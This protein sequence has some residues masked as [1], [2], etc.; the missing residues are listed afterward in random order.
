MPTGKAR[1]FNMTLQ[2]LLSWWN[3]IFILPFGLGLLYLGM[4]TL[5]GW[6]FGEAGSDVGMDHDVDAHLDVDGHL[7]IDHDT[8]LSHD[9]H[10][11]TDSDA[12]DTESNAAH[13]SAFLSALN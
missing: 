4:Y 8:D 1:R 11:E 12:H 10:A 3:L 13:G 9:V 2:W 6:T 7:E 5:S